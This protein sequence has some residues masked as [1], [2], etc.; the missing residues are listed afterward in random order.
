MFNP[1]DSVIISRNDIYKSL[2]E[3]EFVFPAI[4]ACELVSPF[5]HY[6]AWNLT[7]FCT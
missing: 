6:F 1:L 3:K 7:L 5:R 2:Q 4:W